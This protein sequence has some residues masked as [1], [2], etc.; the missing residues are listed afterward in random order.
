MHIPL[1]PV[2]DQIIVVTGATS[3][4]GLSTARKAA[5][6]GATRSNA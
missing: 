2:A 1:K 6:K 3:G 5:A 4:H